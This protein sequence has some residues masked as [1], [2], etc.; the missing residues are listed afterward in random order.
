[1]N[2]FETVVI[3]VVGRKSEMR[4]FGFSTKTE[5]QE[6][7]DERVARNLAKGFEKV[8]DQGDEGLRVS[9]GTTTILYIVRPVGIL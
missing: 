4:M 8:E 9:D 5:A 7:R 1:M 6:D 3:S 2:K